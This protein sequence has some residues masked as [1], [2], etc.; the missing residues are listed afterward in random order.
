M[1]ISC[2]NN[3]KIFLIIKLL[4]LTGKFSLNTFVSFIDYVKTD[5]VR[6]NV[7]NEIYY[8]IKKNTDKPSSFSKC[9]GFFTIDTGRPI[10]ES[11]VFLGKIAAIME[12]WIYFLVL[13]AFSGYRVFRLYKVGVDVDENKLTDSWDSD[14]AYLKYFSFEMAFDFLFCGS[15]FLFNA[16]DY[17][18]EC[19]TISKIPYSLANYCTMFT[20]ILFF[21]FIFLFFLFY[22]ILKGDLSDCSCLKLK[23]I[24]IRFSLTFTY[25]FFMFVINFYGNLIAIVNNVFTLANIVTDIFKQKCNFCN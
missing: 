16:I 14:H 22:F 21:I 8:L 15:L 25:M 24:I 9:T 23:Y 13:F 2:L 17:S 19:V 5:Y 18:T 1:A 6:F 3:N 4:L 11:G 10:Y 7:T 20:L 12:Y